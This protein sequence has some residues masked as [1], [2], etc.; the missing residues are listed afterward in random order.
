M[1]ART[2]PRIGARRCLC[3]SHWPESP[4]AAHKDDAAPSRMRGMPLRHVLR[5][6]HRPCRRRDPSC[7][8]PSL[9]VTQGPV[10]PSG[11]VLSGRADFGASESHYAPVTRGCQREFPPHIVRRIPLSPNIQANTRIRCKAFQHR[12]LQPRRPGGHE[13]CPAGRTHR[14]QYPG[15]P[16]ATRD[17]QGEGGRPGA[18]GLPRG[19]C[20]SREDV[21]PCGAG[22]SPLEQGGCHP[23]LPT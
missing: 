14:E 21:A 10:A 16:G 6:S 19:C 7:G 17:K 8:K 18:S 13:H 23:T 3:P 2:L 4:R 5:C 9:M 1:P 11:W 20:G 22:Y 12:H 15:A